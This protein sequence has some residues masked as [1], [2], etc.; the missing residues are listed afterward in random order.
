VRRPRRRRRIPSEGIYLL[1]NLLTCAGLFCGLCAVLLSGEGQ[2]IRSALAI[3]G[4]M[5]FD[6]LDGKVARATRSSTRFGLEL[7]SLADLVAFGVAP[8]VLAYRWHLAAFGRWGW[9]AC[10]LYV[11]CGAL[12]LAR[13]NLQAYTVESRHF[14]GLPVPAAACALVSL[15][16][17][18][19]Q[20]RGGGAVVLL[21]MYPLALLMVSGLRYPGFKDLGLYHRHPLS[22]LVCLVLLAAL[23]GARPRLMLLLG[24][25]GYVMAGPVGTLPLWRRLARRRQA[26]WSTFGSS[27]PP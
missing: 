2:F 3:L 8:A 27:T 5:L 25:L 6:G 17:C 21:A 19:G 9:L 7:D 16:L 4:A 13:F 14:Q 22:A 15:M 12:R 24:S 18:C 11:I 1:P 23:L 20:T 10:G 26:S